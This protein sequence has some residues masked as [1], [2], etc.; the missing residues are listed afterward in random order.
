MQKLIVIS[1]L[2]HSLLFIPDTAFAKTIVVGPGEGCDFTKISKAL[3]K[4]EPGDV[5]EIMPGTYKE[6]LRMRKGVTLKGAGADKTKVCHWETVFRARKIST[7]KVTGIMFEQLKNRSL[8][9]P[10]IIENCEKGFEFSNNAVSQPHFKP[11][12]LLPKS[13]WVNP[14]EKK[15]K[16]TSKYGED[17]LVKYGDPA[18]IQNETLRGIYVVTRGDN[19]PVVKNQFVSPLTNE[20]LPETSDK[21]RLELYMR[22]PWIG[23]EKYYNSSTRNGR[24]SVNLGK[25]IIPLLREFFF[26]SFDQVILVEAKN[27]TRRFMAS[28]AGVIATPVI[29]KAD[30][31]I[32][33]SRSVTTFFQF[34][35]GFST[36]KG[37]KTVDI[38]GSGTGTAPYNPYSETVMFGNDLEA[39]GSFAK[40]FRAANEAALEDF[41]QNLRNSESLRDLIQYCAYLEAAE[42]ES[43][44]LLAAYVDRFPE[45]KYAAELKK[46]GE[47][48]AYKLAKQE[49]T[50]EAFERFIR[51]NPDNSF[52]SEARAEIEKLRYESATDINTLDEYTFFL[53][54][55]PESQYSEDVRKRMAEITYKRD[56]KAFAEVESS[57]DIG[58]YEAFLEQHP[59]SAFAGT[60]RKRIEELKIEKDRGIFEAACES[61]TREAYRNF[62]R[63]HP[64]NY[65]V[66][67]ARK[68]LKSLQVFGTTQCQGSARGN[69]GLELKGKPE[70][71]S[72]SV[73]KVPCGAR[74]EILS[75]ENDWYLIL[76]RDG[77]RGYLFV[78]DIRK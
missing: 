47:E 46:K 7:G 63:T 33:D 69:Q 77:A 73:G 22:V 3:S 62:I 60:A 18:L 4:A 45:S 39:S 12:N 27:D 17:I 37:G 52:V 76:T 15:S 28:D 57:G 34:L 68:K 16:G 25:M 61:N 74:V 55:Y 64:R 30:G 1:I 38:S 56:R 51:G 21:Y 66:S 41:K 24:I 35:V 20:C 26:E 48:A 29:Q 67:E 50:V 72:S 32:T 8:Y 71:F 75:G 44:Q 65:F 70:F 2:L 36:A 49:D 9:V 42:T 78:E 54:R 5:I 53:S 10:V 19:H 59:D 14:Q 43:P 31:S 13:K 40:A 11:E 58:K 6:K 23:L